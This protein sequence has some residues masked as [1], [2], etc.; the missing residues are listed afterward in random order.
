[1]VNVNLLQ[2]AVASQ[3]IITHAS[4]VSVCL[5]CIILDVMLVQHMETMLGAMDVAE[6]D[7]TYLCDLISL[8]NTWFPLPRIFP[9]YTVKY[10]HQISNAFGCLLC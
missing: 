8:K 5:Q 6:L 2:I 4:L 10:H 7:K 3:T 9:T 1:M